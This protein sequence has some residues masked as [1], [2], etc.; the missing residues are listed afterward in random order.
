MEPIG[1]EFK[2]LAP[3]FK[4]ETKDED[5]T[6]V[7][8][9]AVFDRPHPT[10]SWMLGRDWKDRIDPA[11]FDAALSEHASLGTIPA[12]LFNHDL[13]NVVGAYSAVIKDRDGLRVEGKIAQSAKT[14]AGADLYELMKMGAVTG[15]SIGFTPSKVQLDEK[16]KVRTLQS[17]ELHEISVV[18][19]PAN[20]AARVEDVKGLLESPKIFE[21]QLRDALGLSR[22][23]AKR[24]MS[25][26]WAALLRDAGDADD[27]SDARDATPGDGMQPL[28]DAGDGDRDE[29]LARLRR[30]ASAIQP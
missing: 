8:H 26:G 7:G 5:R 30:L 24:L 28:R 11:A 25:G 21:R 9:G 23:Q 15:L 13:D 20:P 19:I 4:V 3:P 14:P 2:R 17:V 22:E 10:S 12:M 1:R 18:S 27:G 6:F 29:V 16:A